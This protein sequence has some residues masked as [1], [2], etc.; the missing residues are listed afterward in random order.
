MA[1]NFILHVSSPLFKG[2]SRFIPLHLTKLYIWI[3][4]II[5]DLLLAYYNLTFR[6]SI[7]QMSLFKTILQLLSVIQ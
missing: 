4:S 7:S 6:I 5:R 1:E 2:D 3:Q